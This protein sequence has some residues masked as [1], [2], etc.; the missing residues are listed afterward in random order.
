MIFTFGLVRWENFVFMWFESVLPFFL[1]FYFKLVLLYKILI[2]SFAQVILP[3][4][5]FPVREKFSEHYITDWN[6]DNLKNTGFLNTSFWPKKN[7]LH[8]LQ[9][10]IRRSKCLHIWIYGIMLESILK[11]LWAFTSRKSWPFITW[12][13]VHLHS[14]AVAIHVYC[15]TFICFQFINTFRM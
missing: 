2:A 9:L 1:P 10:I 11:L 5:K 3:L 15:F 14:M 6:G 7:C 4:A 13:F 8:W 12:H